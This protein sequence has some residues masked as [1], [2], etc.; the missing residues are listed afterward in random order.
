[1]L[2][3]APPASFLGDLNGQR[4]SF[5][6]GGELVACEIT[7]APGVTRDTTSTAIPAQIHLFYTTGS[8]SDIHPGDEFELN[9]GGT[10]FAKGIIRSN[11][12]ITA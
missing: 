1:M 11:P 4:P 2:T 3:E 12:R 9:V 10:S 5:N 7:C 6:F 8:H